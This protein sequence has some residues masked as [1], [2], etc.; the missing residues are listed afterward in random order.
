MVALIVVSVRRGS[1]RPRTVVELRADEPPGT[2]MDV[3]MVADGTLAPQAGRRIEELAAVSDIGVDL[4]AGAPREV[5]VW[6]H[7]PTR[8]GDTDPIPVE[9]KEG[10]AQIVVRPVGRWLSGG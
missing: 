3:S 5:A 2:G 8:D 7:R 10:D 6:A 4:P 9:V 1:F